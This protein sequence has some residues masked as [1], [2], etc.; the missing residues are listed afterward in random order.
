MNP[1]DLIVLAA[2][3]VFAWTGWR[4]GF[5]AGLLAYALS[6]AKERKEEE[7]RTTVE[8]MALLLLMM[9]HDLSCLV[10]QHP[11]NQ[12]TTIAGLGSTCAPITTKS[13]Y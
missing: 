6:A 9:V 11:A 3:A 7:V 4:Q 12:P 1:A 10:L 2:L 13:M 5:V 8:N